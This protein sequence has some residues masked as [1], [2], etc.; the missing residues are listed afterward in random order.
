MAYRILFLLIVFITPFLAYGVYR[1]ARAEALEEG[2][3]TWPINMLFGIGAAFAL[4]MWIVLIFVDRGERDIC[5]EP[6]RIENGKIIPQREYACE[7]GPIDRG[8]ALSAYPGGKATGVGNP[9]PA[10]PE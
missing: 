8:G 6:S 1:A 10:G 2:R 9:D 3:K 4:I 7:A 5:V